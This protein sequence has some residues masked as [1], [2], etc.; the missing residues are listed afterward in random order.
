MAQPRVTYG[1]SDFGT[2]PALFDAQGNPVEGARYLRAFVDLTANVLQTVDFGLQLNEDILTNVQSVFIDNSNGTT[3]LTVESS[4]TKQRIIIAAGWQY[5]GPFLFANDQKLEMTSADTKTVRIFLYNMPHPAAAWPA[6]N[7]AASETVAAT[8]ADGADVALGTTTDAAIVNPVT[9]GT[10]IAFLKGVVTLLTT[11]SNAVKSGMATP[12]NVAMTGAS[13]ALFASNA[14]AE[15]RTIY[16]DGAAVMYVNFGAAASATA[17]VYAIQPQGYYELP[18]PLY[19]GAVNALA[20]SGT[21][22]V[23]E[24]SA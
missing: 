19:T 18:Q 20:A 5:V 9:A 1:K 23:M 3:P 22:R 13:V 16:N 15:A 6:T 21:A 14:G 7:A 11:I 12:A 2:Y 17:F 10:V 24:Q 8:I 4:L